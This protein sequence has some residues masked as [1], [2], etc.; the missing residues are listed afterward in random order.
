MNA[1]GGCYCGKIRYRL[2]AEP[3]LEAQ[4]HCRPG[5]DISGGGPNYFTMIPEDG[6]H[7]TADAPA[8]FARSDIEGARTREFCPNCGTHLLTRLPGRPVVV[9]KV[10]TL[11]DTSVYSGPK[12]AIHCAEKAAFHT[13]AEGVG[14][15][16]KLPP[17]K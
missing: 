17:P 5:Q 2:D 8:A 7:Y 9:V 14:A 13:I 16:E 3:V 11:D 6:F 4:C 10:G 15:F 12:I 1:T